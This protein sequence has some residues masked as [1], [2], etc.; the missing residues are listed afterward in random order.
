MTQKT[1]GLKT[2]EKKCGKCGE[3]I[4]VFPETKKCPLC[5]GELQTVP[6]SESA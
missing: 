5:D 3:A 2:V 1:S 4:R 6:I